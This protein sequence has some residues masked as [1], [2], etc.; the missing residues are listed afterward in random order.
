MREITENQGEMIERTKANRAFF[1]QLEAEIT[2]MDRLLGE[3]QIDVG[4]QVWRRVRDA[5]WGEGITDDS[6]LVKYKEYTEK[7]VKEIRADHGDK[8]E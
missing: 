6:S 1:E 5:A 8:N 3:H 4:D 2:D 7:Q